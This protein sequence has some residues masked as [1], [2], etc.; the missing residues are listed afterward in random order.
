MHDGSAA[1]HELLQGRGM[2]E[3]SFNQPYA[4]RA[5]KRGFGGIPDQCADLE[6]LF[7]Q[8]LAQAGPDKPGSASNGDQAATGYQAD[9]TLRRTSA[10]AASRRSTSLLLMKSRRALARDSLPDDVRGREWIGTSST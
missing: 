10:V 7:Q 1:G 6:A 3:V 5:Q 9:A 2:A 4:P 8:A